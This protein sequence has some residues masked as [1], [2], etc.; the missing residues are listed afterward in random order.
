MDKFKE[1]DKK[2]HTEISEDPDTYDDA[3][4]AAARQVQQNIQDLID[5]WW[6]N[7]N[8]TEEQQKLRNE[9][10][11]NGKPTTDEFL[12]KLVEDA[13]KDPKFKAIMEKAEK[14]KRRYEIIKDVLLA[15]FIFLLMLLVSIHI[16]IMEKNDTTKDSQS[17][18]HSFMG[19]WGW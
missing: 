19:G 3:N 12:K 1:T 5:E 6:I 8:L 2:D 14:K 4:L 13:R 7:N 18:S 11:P 17:R 10:F 15:A 16:F 9:L